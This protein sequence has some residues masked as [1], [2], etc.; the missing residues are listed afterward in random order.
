MGEK[1]S[2]TLPKQDD[3]ENNKITLR[4]LQKPDWLKFDAET[5]TFFVDEGSTGVKQVGIYTVKILLSDT[6]TAK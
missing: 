6:T 2:Y 3:H 1:W 4:I 5:T